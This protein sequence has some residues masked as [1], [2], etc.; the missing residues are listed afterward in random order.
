MRIERDGTTV[1][2]EGSSLRPPARE[3]DCGN[4]G[5]TMRMIAGV[6]AGQNFE[7]T[8]IGDASLSAR[9]MN[10]IV[11]AAGTDG[12]KDPEL[13][14]DIRRLTFVVRNADGHPL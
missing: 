10:R 3:L 13:T 8:L 5:S 4:S 12:R 11:D 6:L 2:I 9:P 14:T 7:S 1:R